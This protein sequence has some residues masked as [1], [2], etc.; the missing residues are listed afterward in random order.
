MSFSIIFNKKVEDNKN[1]ELLM[2]RIKPGMLIVSFSLLLLLLVADAYSGWERTEIGP[3]G[4]DYYSI[5][6]GEGRNDGVKRLYS[7]TRM[8]KLVE[9]TYSDND[10]RV[11]SC[12]SYS[13]YGQ[14]STT[15]VGD[16]RGDG[17]V[18]IYVASQNNYIYEYSYNDANGEW[19]IL[20]VGGFTGWI[21]GGADIGIPRND[22]VV[23]VVGTGVQKTIEYTW[24][25][26]QWEETFRITGAFDCWAI[27]I[28]D[29]RNDS[30]NSIYT[31]DGDGSNNCIREYVWNASTEEYDE[32]V[33]NAPNQMI[34]TA[35][36]PGRNDGVSRVYGSGRFG[37]IYEFTYEN[38]MWNMIDIQDPA[39]PQL[40]R[41]GLEIGKNIEGQFCL[42]SV[43]QSWGTA[44][45]VRQHIYVEE[46]WQ[47]NIIDTYSGATINVGYGDARNDDKPG[48][49]VVGTA[50]SLLCEY[51]EYDDLGV[52]DEEENICNDLILSNYPNPFNPETQIFYSIQKADYSKAGIVIYNSI[53]EVVDQLDLNPVAGVAT[54]SVKFDGSKLNSGVYYY[55]LVI[56]GSQVGT[57]KMILIR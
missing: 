10:W 42:Y 7:G 21:P 36:G 19:D 24:S 45:S 47:D 4:Y 38:D 49:Y 2:Y 32:T 50:N 13:G 41:Y 57:N 28:G 23:R 30:V 17:V 33:L 5:G 26:T 43:A 6:I 16:G 15:T 40:S 27:N 44:G 9:W 52:D 12:G 53:G 31:S 1:K 29:G 56:D 11:E 51:M 35:I 22:G 18:R 37:H 46:E 3:D 14:A 54:G 8:G 34:K 20:T 48:V 39:S 55:K 25:G